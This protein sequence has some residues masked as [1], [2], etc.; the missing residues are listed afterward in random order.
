M[1]DEERTDCHRLLALQPTSLSV[2]HATDVS[3]NVSLKDI[4]MVENLEFWWTFT[5]AEVGNM[6]MSFTLMTVQHL[7]SFVY[8]PNGIDRS[9]IY[10]YLPGAHH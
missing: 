3:L 9:L 5:E 10:S 6:R 7:T 4:S 1:H 2:D 8:Y